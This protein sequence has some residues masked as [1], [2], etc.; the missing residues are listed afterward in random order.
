MRAEELGKNIIEGARLSIGLTEPELKNQAARFKSKE[1]E[2]QQAE[3]RALLAF[4]P[5]L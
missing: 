4:S 1:A 5:S 2:A 3:V